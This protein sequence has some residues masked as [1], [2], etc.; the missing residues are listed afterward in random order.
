MKQVSFIIKTSILFCVLS[1]GFS[2][3]GILLAEKG[4]QINPMISLTPQEVLEHLAWGLIAGI[5]TLSFRYII[6]T[7]LFAVLIDSDHLVGLTHVDAISRVS[8]SIAFGIIAAVVLVLVFGK[9]NY[10]LGAVAFSGMLSHLSFD[11]FA[12]DDGKFPI[13][14]PFYNHQVSFPNAEWIY[15]EIAAIAIIGVITVFITKK[16]TKIIT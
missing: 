3:L 1:A 13:F 9:K 14:T 6:L 8:H 4:P 10:L 15:F 5:V 16:E 12:A 2:L 7:G 11:I